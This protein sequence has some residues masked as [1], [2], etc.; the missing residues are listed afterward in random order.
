MSLTG[1]YSSNDTDV[2][3]FVADANGNTFLTDINTPRNNTKTL[4]VSI[5]VQLLQGGATEASIE[6]A[7]H[8]FIATSE[9]RE[10]IHRS[11]VEMCVQISTCQRLYRGSKHLGRLLSLLKAPLKPPRLVLK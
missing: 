2:Q 4:G 6:R 5:R 8:S 3:G 9:E 7:R 1:S 10:R 11:V